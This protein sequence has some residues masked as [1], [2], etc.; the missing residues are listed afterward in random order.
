M[1][2]ADGATGE[3]DA[4]GGESGG[5]EV[6][7]GLV[8]ED[9]MLLVESGR[10]AGERVALSA[11]TCVIGRSSKCALVLRRSAGVSRRHTKIR[12]AGGTYEISDCGSRNGTRV[13][14]RKIGVGLLLNDGDLIQISDERIRFR[15]PSGRTG[16]VDSSALLVEP[17]PLERRLPSREQSGEVQRTQRVRVDSPDSLLMTKDGGTAPSRPVPPPLPSRRNP[18]IP[19]QRGALPAAP[20]ALFTSQVQ[21]LSTPQPPPLVMP[22]ATTLPVRARRE[23]PKGALFALGILLGIVVLVGGVTVWDLALNEARVT[24]ALEEDAQ[25]LWA[26]VDAALREPAELAGEEPAPVLA[27]VGE[28]KA[29]A[30]NADDENANEAAEAAASATPKTPARVEGLRAV[31]PEPAVEAP[32]GEVEE[33]VDEPAPVA[34]AAA[35]SLGGVVEVKADATG[36]VRSIGVSTGDVVRQGDTLLVLERSSARLARKLKALLREEKEFERHAA[37]GNA[38]AQRDLEVV[39]REIARLEK[40]AGTTEVKAVVGGRVDGLL[41]D[42]GARVKSSDVLVRIAAGAP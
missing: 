13:N 33:G 41:V 36:R 14:G 16:D 8:P 27:S 3:G 4:A 37:L 32:A 1:F 2:D 7:G 18:A 12:Y 42:V 35:A 6:L 31:A 34:E 23:P 26:G 29:K 10:H 9:A 15:G 40:R 24:R 28:Q 30:Q 5:T 39:R 25:L 11:G 20:T 19:A 22:S 38:R 21:A 17:E